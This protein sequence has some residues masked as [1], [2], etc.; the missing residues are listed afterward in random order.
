MMS[1]SPTDVRG[2]A[3]DLISNGVYVLTACTEDTI[4][5]AAV[6]WVSQVSSQPPMIMVALRRNS[7]LVWAVRQA[8]RFALNILAADQEELAGK[9]L[10][11]FTV[12]ATDGTLAGYVFRSSAAHCPLLTDALAWVECRVAGEAHTPGDHNLLL[13]EVTAAG[14]RRQD[15]PMVLGNTRWSYGGTRAS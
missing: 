6:S 12:P 8:H 2:H 14:V 1:Q 10:T 7:H 4:H 3:L 5:A 15:Q 11:H 13:G 9:F